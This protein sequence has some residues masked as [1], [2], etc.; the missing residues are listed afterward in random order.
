MEETVSRL[1][2]EEQMSSFQ[3]A[4]DCLTTALH[5]CGFGQDAKN[6]NRAIQIEI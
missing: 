5:H 3:T 4:A 6:G 1:Q 2:E